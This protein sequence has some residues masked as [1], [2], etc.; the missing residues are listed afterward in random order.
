MKRF[1]KV[2]K[3]QGGELSD[4][5]VPLPTFGFFVGGFPESSRTDRWEIFV[6][7]LGVEK[8]GTLDKN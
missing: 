8:N 7:T 4:C 3:I 2:E 1:A 6:L 5:K